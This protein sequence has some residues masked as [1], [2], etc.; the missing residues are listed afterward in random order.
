MIYAL[1]FLCVP[2]SAQIVSSGTPL[3]QQFS[4]LQL[5]QQMKAL[6]SGR[7]VLTSTPTFQ[8]GM[9]SSGTVTIGGT[10]N[11]PSPAT[12]SMQPGTTIVFSTTGWTYA[13]SN[14]STFTWVNWVTPLGGP[15]DNV[16]ASTFVVVSTGVFFTN[17]PST[18][19]ATVC[20]DGRINAT[21][22]GAFLFKP[23]T[24]TAGDF[25]SDV[26][27]SGVLRQNGSPNNIG[28]PTF[29]I[30]CPL[31]VIGAQINANTDVINVCFGPIVPQD[32]WPNRRVF[33]YSATFSG[34]GNT[35]INYERGSCFY[36]GDKSGP[37]TS[38]I[39][40]Y[41]FYPPA[42]VQITGLVKL[43]RGAQVPGG[44]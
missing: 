5:Q 22:T 1:L 32:N 6:Q 10:M 34:V 11:F 43:I 28:G 2:S 16:V 9:N 8:S 41:G 3:S 18:V 31:N 37:A 29:R 23:S 20:F 24:N 33:E 14:V 35:A 13:N 12:L 19:T 39:T 7:P 27:L 38:P 44:N 36:Q 30:G 15:D 26:L 17:L 42:G 40:G 21:T 4:V 25:Q